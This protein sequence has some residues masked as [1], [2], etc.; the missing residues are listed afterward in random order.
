MAV[1]DAFG[2][3]CGA[4]GIHNKEIVVV[5]GA[6]RGFLCGKR[7]CKRIIIHC[8][9]RGACDTIFAADPLLHGKLALCA[10]L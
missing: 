10:N 2:A 6:D 7:G 3:S 1:H 4:G 5:P 9:V 8:P